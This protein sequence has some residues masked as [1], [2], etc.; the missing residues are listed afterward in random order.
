MHYGEKIK[1]L[2]H[3][4]GMNQEDIAAKIGRTRALI[5]HIEQTGKVHHET[6]LQIIKLFNISEEEFRDFKGE[7]IKISNSKDQVK[8]EIELAELKENVERIK[9]ENKI[10]KDL[11]ESQ[12]EII[13]LLKD[14]S[15]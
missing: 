9:K 2:R 7:D 15:K 13:N 8:A 10:L 4:N 14:K 1:L 3:L 12:K 5:S 6:L 11:V